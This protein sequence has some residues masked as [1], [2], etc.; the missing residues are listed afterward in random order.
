MSMHDLLQNLP[1]V[2]VKETRDGLTRAAVASEQFTA[3]LDELVNC[4]TLA[5]ATYS[6]GIEEAGA[7]YSQGLSLA[8]LYGTDDR[9]EKGMFGVHALLHDD[10]TQSWLLLSTEV[11][12]HNPEY[13]S[14]TR[15]IMAAQW[16]E[17]YLFDMFGVTPVGHPDL[18]RLV[19]HESVPLEIYPLRKD[20]DPYA[21]LER[22]DIPF[23][24]QQVAGEGVYE[25]GV[26]PV[27]NRVAESIHFRL[28]STGERI[29]TFESKPYFKHKGV[30]KLL[31]GK[32]YTAG[33]PFIDRIGGD[34]AVSHALAFAQAIEDIDQTQVPLRAKAIRSL[35]N[36]LERVIIHIEDLSNI[37]AIGAGYTAMKRGFSVK[38]RLMRLSEE[39]SGNRFLRG[40]I[41][42]GGLSKDLSG[43]EVEK[44]RR[45]SVEAIDEM[46]HL[47]E[48][49]LR[50]DGLRDRL[51]TTGVLKK[52]A[53]KVY[54]AVGL[55]ARASG[56]DR[57]V[58]R[59]H[60]YAAYSRFAPRV[61]TGSQGDVYSRFKLRFDELL[62]CR[63]LII[64]MTAHLGDGGVR[65]PCH[66]ELGMGVSAVE[67]GRGETLYVVYI[68][69]GHISRIAIRDASFM[70]W[71]LLHE[72]IPTNVL[73]DFP[74]CARSLGLSVAANDL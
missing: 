60:P 66:P 7:L 26:G 43:E 30:E 23:P 10:T 4:R 59:D 21:P 47:V 58:R 72:M 15:F 54:G 42:P 25:V 39:I 35:L 5:A 73:S 6:L 32:T 48:R 74:L 70:N 11:H 9:V 19:H 22:D 36:E 33:L 50:A 45:V 16:H 64:D 12:A 8:H 71:P 56:V 34:S 28:N 40:L 37:A 1:S 46:Q 51:E 38:E 68:K 31:E 67:G 55:V 65:V 57:D 18:R 14:A 24:M 49:A 61:L 20:F 52:D 2:T 63:R 53:A 29:M 13:L 17:R 41:I 3:A 27:Y 44:I 62:E 69:D